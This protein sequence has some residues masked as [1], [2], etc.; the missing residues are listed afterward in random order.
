MTARQF[1]AWLSTTGMSGV[2]AAQALGV[3]PNSITRF[4]QRGGPHTLRLACLALYHRL[5]G[6]SLPWAS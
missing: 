2:E 6:S 3:H 1:E 4:R 5:D